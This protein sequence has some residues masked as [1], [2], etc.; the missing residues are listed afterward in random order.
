MSQELKKQVHFSA[1]EAIQDEGKEKSVESQ[2]KPDTKQVQTKGLW[3][4]GC[5]REKSAEHKERLLQHWIKVCKNYDGERKATAI[6][7]SRLDFLVTLARAL[8]DPLWNSA[9]LLVSSRE[10]V[11]VRLSVE[12]VEAGLFPSKVMMLVTAR[13]VLIDALTEKYEGHWSVP[14]LLSLIYSWD[15]STIDNNQEKNLS[16]T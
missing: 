16:L 12:L 1:Q 6:Y 2:A 15:A 9:D 10:S 3:N 14:A 4:S 8:A 13:I 5:Y 7:A 11:Q